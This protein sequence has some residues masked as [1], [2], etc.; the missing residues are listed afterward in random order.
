MQLHLS[1]TALL[2]FSRSPQAEALQKPLLGPRSSVKANVQLHH[3]LQQ[4]TLRLLKSTG[5]PFYHWTEAQQTTTGFGQ[6]LSEA[7]QHV[8]NQGYQKILIV[9]NDSPLLTRRHLN[10]AVQV[11]QE[12]KSVL[13]ATPKGGSYLIGFSQKE[14]EAVD[15]ENLAWQSAQLGAQLRN[16][17]GAAKL[18]ELRQLDDLN[19]LADLIRFSSIRALS[20]VLRFFLG[21]L[22]YFKNTVSYPTETSTNL[23]LALGLRGPPLV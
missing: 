23:A 3:H 15:F 10:Q 13:G 4:K 14:F 20:H 12:N 9:G 8:F 5:L 2:F 19:Q 1:Q 16:F 17:L 18:V 6:R 22:Q 7:V 11:L 21:F